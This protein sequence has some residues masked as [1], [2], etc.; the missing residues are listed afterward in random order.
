MI[1]L[2]WLLIHK[3]N[4][5]IIKS[6]LKKKIAKFENLRK[7][8]NSCFWRIFIIYIFVND[9]DVKNADIKNKLKKQ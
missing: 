9:I 7:N 3:L 6:H 5:P 2:P 4:N 8:D 1:I